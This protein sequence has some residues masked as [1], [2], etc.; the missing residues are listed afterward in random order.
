[1][2]FLSYGVSGVRGMESVDVSPIAP[3]HHTCPVDGCVAYRAI[4][5][6]FIFCF[7]E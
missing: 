5:N 2:T 4:R 6:L 7:Q 3:R 1:M